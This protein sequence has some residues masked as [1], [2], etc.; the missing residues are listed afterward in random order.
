MTLPNI[1]R[2]GAPG[3][4]ARKVYNKPRAKSRLRTATPL[5]QIEGPQLVHRP[6]AGYPDCLS[7]DGS[8]VDDG[9][10]CIRLLSVDSHPLFR[11]GIAAMIN[12]QKD[13]ALVAQASGGREAIQ[14]YREHLPHVTLMEAHLPDF[15]GIE[16]M[17]AIKSEFPNARII[18]LTT[19][20]GDV[21]VQRALEAGASGYL[22][23]NIPSSELLHAVR[24][25]HAGKKQIPQAL[26]AQLVEHMGDQNL[27]IR[28]MEVLKRVAQGNR[29][30]DIGE[31]LSI[32][33]GT[34]KVH[35]KHILEKLG[36][37][38][39]TEAIAIAVRRGIIHI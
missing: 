12:S 24:Q 28:E 11:E 32:S 19:S 36:A 25:V 37:K 38:D 21:E 35:M 33:E 26:A 9:K 2:F 17:I 8:A 34:V 13:M 1:L 27:S 15:G 10:V 31:L 29:N 22:L 5:E 7:P 30:R 14:K 23:K 20:E 39:R 16:A 4:A 18:M 6:P 3:Y